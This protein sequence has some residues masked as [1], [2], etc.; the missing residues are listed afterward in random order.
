[1][2]NKN[3]GR[4]LTLKRFC[5][6]EKYPIRSAEW[7]I[8]EGDGTWDDPY[9]LCLEM[10]FGE[11]VDL[12]EDTKTLKAEPSWEVS[13]PALK[14][15][16]W[17]LLPGFTM[18]LENEEEDEEAIF[19]YCEHQPTICNKVKVLRVWG[20]SLLLHITAKTEDVNFYDGSKPKNELELTAWFTKQED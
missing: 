15:S 8:M 10:D 3:E 11:G 13:F 16:R 20:N 19:Y 2:K 14:L 12:H 9:T 18:K 4:F 7:Y 5:G 1:M 6:E 17:K